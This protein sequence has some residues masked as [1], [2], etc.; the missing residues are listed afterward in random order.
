MTDDAV[1]PMIY[2]DYPTFPTGAFPGIGVS[3]VAEPSLEETTADQ[4]EA[5]EQ[6]LD[7]LLTFMARLT[8]LVEYGEQMMT[9]STKDRLKLMMSSGK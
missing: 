4:L 1:A 8:P 2:R 6:K 7:D 5:I 3:D 9:L